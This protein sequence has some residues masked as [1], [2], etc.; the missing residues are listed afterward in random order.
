[1]FGAGGKSL[2]TEGQKKACTPKV[3]LVKALLLYRK[4]SFVPSEKHRYMLLFMM[5]VPYLKHKWP[6]LQGS[7][8]SLDSFAN[9]LYRN[10]FFHTKNRHM[11]FSAF[12]ML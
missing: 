4:G 10:L 3:T 5:H 9:L 2:P 11:S 12:P 6:A 1:V 7:C 8:L